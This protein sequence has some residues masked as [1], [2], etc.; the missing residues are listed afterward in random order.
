MLCLTILNFGNGTR[1]IELYRIA[2]IRGQQMLR[3]ENCSK[4]YYSQ[5]GV[6]LGLHKIT[7]E[8]EAGEFI[9]I[10]GESGSGKSTVMNVLS[11]MDSYE[12]GEM[13]VEGQPTSHYDESDWEK[14]RKEKIAFIFQNYNLIDS[15]TVLQNVESALL[16]QGC[17]QSDL[18][19]K[20]L[21]CIQ[22]VDL[23]NQKDH[24][25]SQLS[26]GQKQRLSIA[27]ALAKEAPIIV[28]DEPTGNLDSENGEQIMKLLKELSKD[29]L[30]LMVTHN[31]GQA[32]PY[33][34]R[35]ITMNDGEVIE[36]Q[37]VKHKENLI[38][39]ILIDEQS[40]K[41]HTQE[42]LKQDGILDEKIIKPFTQRLFERRKSAKKSS[43]QNKA[44]QKLRTYTAKRF[45][46]MNVTSQHGKVLAIVSFM[47]FMSFASFVFLGAIFS[48]L[49]DTSTKVYNNSAFYNSDNQRII[50][51]H[52][53]NRGITEEDMANFRSLERV[54]M[55][56]EYD[57]PNDM[58][59]FYE[60]GVD[61]RVSYH[62]KADPQ[63]KGDSSDVVLLN[64]NKYIKSSS[65]ITEEDLSS[66]K[67]PEAVN[68]IVLYSS[69]D[70]KLGDTI[71]FFFQDKRNWSAGAFISMDMKVVGILKENT[72]Q[73]YFEKDL[74][75][76]MMCNANMTRT[77][78][79]YGTTKN[80]VKYFYSIVSINP[81]L[82]R[83]T[84]RV[85]NTFL[86]DNPPM[87]LRYMDYLDEESQDFLLEEVEV[88][89]TG[90]ASTQSV[91]EVSPEL[92]EL[93]FQGVK[94]TQASIYVEDY[95]YV[96]DTM[97]ALEQQGYDA[98]SPLQ[99]SSIQYDTAKVRAR[100]VTL[101][102]SIVSLLVISI[103]EVILV[104]S[105]LKLKKNDFI[106]LR[107]IGLEQSVIDWMN[108]YEIAFY[109]GVA[110]FITILL[111]L[112]LNACQVTVIVNLVK[113]YRLGHYLMLILLNLT[114]SFVIALR[115]NQY[116]KK[117]GKITALSEQ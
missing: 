10:T 5:T 25:A 65:C 35:K 117:R 2:F 39:T 6:T 17:R 63:D 22:Q 27:R 98:I 37:M 13:Y 42:E 61:Y 72:K 104:N 88:A 56:D 107:L 97:K 101:V 40:K 54:T 74:S 18:K 86:K 96:D 53:D 43:T 85:S 64:Y 38:D 67:M 11:G 80:N 1:Y 21:H 76:L 33:V 60:A 52:Q 46:K 59:Y 30:V 70:S 28:A 50:V 106:I 93:M 112:L 90:N 51:R 68:E 92:F 102:I 48:N 62:T 29:K 111:V 47:L 69:G 110:I 3:L 49:D 116:L 89:E 44:S 31:Y 23:F 113:Y 75:R 12:E 36:D 95:A 73:V 91:V 34:T 79:V 55:V 100:V 84:V 78:F 82:E 87:L 15:Y 4:Y 114:L 45:A 9:A 20:A 32:E 24:R 94:S 71:R 41:I 8:F 26:S 7:L 105:L 77:A 109:Q 115:F 57:L 99:A 19:E 66:G 83:D 14:Y 58:Y 103:L 16:V 81:E 108:Y